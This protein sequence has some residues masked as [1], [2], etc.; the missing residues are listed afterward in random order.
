M[1]RETVVAGLRCRPGDLA[2]IVYSRMPGMRGKWVAVVEWCEEHGRWQ[3]QLLDGPCLGI[4]I[5]DARPIHSS[6][7]YFRDSSLEPIAR[8]GYDARADA[9]AVNPLQIHLSVD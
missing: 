4:S 6:R 9:R 1:D 5:R 7:G 8:Q 3:V 2:K